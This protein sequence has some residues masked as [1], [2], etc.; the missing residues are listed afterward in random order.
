MSR[1]M[2]FVLLLT[3]ATVAMA[4]QPPAE[5]TAAIRLNGY[6]VDPADITLRASPVNLSVW[7]AKRQNQTSR[8]DRQFPQ[9]EFSPR[10]RE[11]PLLK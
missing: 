1:F 7:H 3:L 2:I 8:P 10:N 4:Q 5:I 9:W 11:L 6:T